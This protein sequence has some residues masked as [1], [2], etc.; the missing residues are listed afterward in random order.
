MMFFQLDHILHMQYDQM[1]QALL[2]GWTMGEVYAVQKNQLI[3][4]LE[5][6]Q[7]REYSFSENCFLNPKPN[8]VFHRKVKQIMQ[9]T[10]QEPDRLL[11]QV[12]SEEEELCR[13]LLLLIRRV[14]ELKP[15]A[16]RHMTGVL[17]AK[18]NK[19]LV[20]RKIKVTL[21]EEECIM[22]TFL[23]R[24]EEISL[25]K[26][27]SL[28]QRNG[29]S[30][31]S[32]RTVENVPKS[33]KTDRYVKKL[34]KKDAEETFVSVPENS[35]IEV[36]VE[37]QEVAPEDKSV[38]EMG[39]TGEEKPVLVPE[40]PEEEAF[41]EVQEDTVEEA[42][43]EVQKD[44]EEEPL[45]EAQEDIEE[46]ISV[47]VQE[48]LEEEKIVE[49]KEIF[50]EEKTAQI[51]ED[52]EEENTAETRNIIPEEKSDGM[53]E[54][55]LEE[56]PQDCI[57]KNVRE[58]FEHTLGGAKPG[59]EVYHAVAFTMGEITYFRD[60]PDCAVYFYQLCDIDRI[61]DEEDFYER[62]GHCY[63]DNKMGQ[64]SASLKLMY[65]A[66][67]NEAFREKNK[68]KLAKC[69]FSEQE[70]ETYRAR[71]IRVGRTKYEKPDL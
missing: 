53:P 11:F 25:E 30:T 4:P 26:V 31:G 15:F 8:E 1:I 54:V 22:P 50:E 71:C 27:F 2:D 63:L 9:L 45:V 48:N 69:G 3:F 38:Y 51:Q 52:T 36:P 66:K 35:E 39:F 12:D 64:F 56:R 10:E 21:D 6:G 32:R 67:L 44:T 58:L 14:Y 16:D 49:T 59:S 61:V 17:L 42:S 62:L 41:V 33:E 5:N 20:K 43:V 28:L 70:L 47:E 68:D 7:V 23:Y 13:F 37:V 19:R 40:Y 29:A 65:K 24:G 18:L 55:A 57:P 46:E 34:M 60:M